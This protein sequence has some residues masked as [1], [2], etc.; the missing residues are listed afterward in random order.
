MGISLRFPRYLHTKR[1][2][3]HR[4]SDRMSRDSGE[5][6]DNVYS[7]NEL[8]IRNDK[9]CP[10]CRE[11]RTRFSYRQLALVKHGGYGGDEEKLLEVCRCSVRVIETISRNPKR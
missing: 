3:E 9:R 1:K 5:S 11:I 10:D 8:A 7:M 6:D 4:R 2:Q